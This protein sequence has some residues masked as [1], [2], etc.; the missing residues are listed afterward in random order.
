MPQTG[1]FSWT[2]A[3]PK[4]RISAGNKTKGKKR[5]AED[6]LEKEDDRDEFFVGSD[7]E[8]GSDPDASD[9][10]EVEE[11]AAEKRLRV[12]EQQPASPISS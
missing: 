12:G 9:A 11:T 5:R 1:E 4:A 10:D 7:A 3:K 2:M 6:L 8:A